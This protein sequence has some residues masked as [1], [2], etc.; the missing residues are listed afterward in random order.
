MSTLPHP[1]FAARPD[2]LRE[3]CYPAAQDAKARYLR[4]GAAADAE[5]LV[6]AEAN[7]TLAAACQCAHDRVGEHDDSPEVYW[8]VFL[9]DMESQL[10][11]AQD[12]LHAENTRELGRHLADRVL[13][14]QERLVEHYLYVAAVHGL[15]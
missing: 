10:S 2:W 12:V 11:H 9:R 5:R 8:L 14:A 3:D 13:E 6:L 1:D 15:D 4:S 7:E